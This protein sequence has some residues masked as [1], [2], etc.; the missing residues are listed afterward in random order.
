LLQL[1]KVKKAKEEEIVK[2]NYSLQSVGSMFK[3]AFKQVDKNIK[4]MNLLN[5]FSK[6]NETGIP[7]DFHYRYVPIKK[8]EYGPFTIE[9]WIV[10]LQH[11]ICKKQADFPLAL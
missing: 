10:I 4:R 11:S 9:E 2:H 5:Q 1:P 8:L 6:N 7:E 3:N